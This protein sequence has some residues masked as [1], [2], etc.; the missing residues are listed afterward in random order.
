MRTR[1]TEIAVTHT[2]V[3]RRPMDAFNVDLGFIKRDVTRVSDDVLA[4]QEDRAR[5]R[6]E[7]MRLKR[8]M[9]ELKVSNTLAA[10]DRDKIKKEF[11]SMRVWVSGF[12]YEVMGRGIVEARP[13]K[14]I[15][16]LAVYG[17]AKHSESQGPP[18]APQCILS[19]FVNT[20][21]YEKLILWFVI[22]ERGFLSSSSMNK[23]DNRED[24]T[25]KGSVFS[26]LASKITNIDGKMIGKDGKPLL[27]VRRVVFHKHISVA[28]VREADQ[29]CM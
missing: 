10:M 15:D 22:M 28:E 18:D 26:D 16:V 23:K 17:D 19:S 14:S 27:V 9:D 20:A 24:K 5:D 21:A 1:Q 3:D 11:F 6:E 25:K 12:M 4:L 7:N 29:A 2:E 13:S 8:R